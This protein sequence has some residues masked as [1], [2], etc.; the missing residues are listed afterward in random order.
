MAAAAP[1]DPAP[2]NAIIVV[3]AVYV[4]PTQPPPQRAL[5][6]ER[7]FPGAPCWYTTAPTRKRDRNER[8]DTELTWVT[9]VFPPGGQPAF[10]GICISQPRQREGK[11][12]IGVAISGA[13]TVARR[14]PPVDDAPHLPPNPG[15]GAFF[16]DDGKMV[17]G[18]Q[19][20]ATTETPAVTRT[21]NLVL[22]LRSVLPRVIN[23]DT[24][25]NFDD[26]ARARLVR[27]FC[28]QS[29]FDGLGPND[30]IALLRRVWGGTA[31][32][33]NVRWEDL[34]EGIRQTCEGTQPV[35]DNIALLGPI[36]TYVCHNA[37][38]A[39]REETEATRD[40]VADAL[41]DL[42]GRRLRIPPRVQPGVVQWA[43]VLDTGSE[44]TVRV[45]LR[46]A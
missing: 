22:F 31:L 1:C 2:E 46:L 14:K 33:P 16:V 42:Y 3:C 39:R 6:T 25:R 44:D 30:Q 10:A 24:W 8:D 32:R 15:D 4:Q 21:R 7:I 43:R 38:I 27:L 18:T 29:E 12:E 13:I 28:I 26:N 11:I 37:L 34:R 19:P 17:F 20:A 9:T 35:E 45:L 5:P 41:R 36:V 40:D 23:A